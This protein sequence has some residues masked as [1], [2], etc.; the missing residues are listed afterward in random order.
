MDMADKASTK[1][2]GIEYNISKFFLT[3]VGLMSGLCTFELIYLDAL[4]KSL[5]SVII[6]DSVGKTSL[7]CR[8][9]EKEFDEDQVPTIFETYN[10]EYE[11]NGQKKILRYNLTRSF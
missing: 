7:L 5:L 9:C 2:L 4:H 6:G 11:V 8:F 10:K 3:Y 1:K